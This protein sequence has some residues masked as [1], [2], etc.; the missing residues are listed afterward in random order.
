M[1][2]AP[3]GPKHDDEACSFTQ[4]RG[5]AYDDCGANLMCFQ[6]TCHLMCSDIPTIRVLGP[7]YAYDVNICD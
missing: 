2:C 6:G 4:D 7:E 5:G 3:I 1:S